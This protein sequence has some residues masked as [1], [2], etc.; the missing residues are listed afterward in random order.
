VIHYE[1]HGSGPPLLLIH[2]LGDSIRVWRPILARL[3][4]EREA[5]AVDLPGFGGSPVLDRA[6]TVPA[7]ADALVA[8]LEELGLERVEV[9]GN[10]LG[11]WLALELLRRGRAT[12]AVAL[13]PAGFWTTREA[14]FADRQLAAS[15]AL[16]RA[17]GPG[18]AA[19]LMSTPAGR[20]ALLG[21]LVGRPWKMEAA[22]AT[23]ALVHL[24]RCAG[25]DATRQE[26]LGSHFQGG[27]ELAGRGEAV[28]AWGTRDH[29]LLPRQAPRAAAAI[30]GARLVMLPG[31]G[32]V[33]V[34]DEPEWVAELVLGR[35]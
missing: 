22:D 34:T 21:L 9:A 11:G 7:L 24:G 23:T 31:A 15:R 10:S 25:F 16:A 14:R 13:S 1:R 17:I 35:G 8:L 30:P 6:P 5:I 28:I 29:L 27:S 12:R 19:A 2:G 20:T 3:G 4:T 26:L 32:H 33:P 18:L